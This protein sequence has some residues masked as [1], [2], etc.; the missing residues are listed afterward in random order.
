MLAAMPVT[1]CS[2]SK[3]TV[4]HATTMAFV[5]LLRRLMHQGD[6]GARVVPIKALASTGPATTR[7]MFSG[8]W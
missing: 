8:V 5:R 1:M 4:A 3:R 7:T 6:F 2:V